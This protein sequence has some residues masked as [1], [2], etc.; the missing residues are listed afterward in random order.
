MNYK[1]WV[2]RQQGIINWLKASLQREEELLKT[3]EE[4]YHRTGFFNDPSSI[5][6]Q[7]KPE[8]PEFNPRWTWKEKLIY[9]L[10][11]ENQPLTVNGFTDTLKELEPDGDYLYDL[12]GSISRILPGLTKSGLFIRFPIPGRRAGYYVFPY[13]MN[14]NGELL[15]EHRRKILFL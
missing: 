10:K 14:E 6:N 3:V 13:W 12:K 11:L 5:S 9:V 8:L 15:E 1:E 7:G 2:S 4:Q